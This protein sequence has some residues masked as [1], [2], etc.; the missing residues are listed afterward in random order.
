[1]GTKWNLAGSLWT[2]GNDFHCES[3]QALPQ[4]AQRDCGASTLGD[5]QKPDHGPGQPAVDKPE[6]FGGLDQMMSR[7]PFQPQ[8]F[9]Y[10]C[11]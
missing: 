2:A 9:C 1:M 7:D 3:D 4:V 10:L 11:H 8:L 5:T 6:W